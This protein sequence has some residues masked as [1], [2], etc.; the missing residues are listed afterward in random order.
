[1]MVQY[2]DEQLYRLRA[3]EI[4]IDIESDS[5]LLIIYFMFSPVLVLTPGT[6]R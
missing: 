5:F 1:M 2:I 6:V 3:I 4:D